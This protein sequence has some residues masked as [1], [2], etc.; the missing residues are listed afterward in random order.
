LL[1]GHGVKGPG[2]AV[3][4]LQVGKLGVNIFLAMHDF[5]NEHAR[6]HITDALQAPGGSRHGSDQV[7]LD[8]VRGLEMIDVRVEQEL[9]VRLGFDLQDDDVRVESVAGQILAG[10]RGAGGFAF[11]FRWHG[12][13]SP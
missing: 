4:V 6:F 2:R 11:G 10:L 3:L 8:H 12:A 9:E 5:L 1:V 7:P 13:S